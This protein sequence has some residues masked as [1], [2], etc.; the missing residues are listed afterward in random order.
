MCVCVCVCVFALLSKDFKDSA[1]SK[2]LVFFRGVLA[3][4]PKK[5]GL[6]GQGRYVSFP[7]QWGSQGNCSKIG[8]FPFSNRKRNRARTAAEKFYGT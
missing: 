6:E 4:L 8:T 2:I 1:E 5:Q 7:R 3:F